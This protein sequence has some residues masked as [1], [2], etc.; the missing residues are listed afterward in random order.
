MNRSLLLRRKTE[1]PHN[2]FLN[3]VSMKGINRPFYKKI[4]FQL[5]G[6]KFE[7][8]GKKRIFLQGN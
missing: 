3:V 7:H 5:S 6:D 4:L 2:F 8:F 1:N